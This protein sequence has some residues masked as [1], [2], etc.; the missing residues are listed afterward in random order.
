MA[1]NLKSHDAAAIGWQ[2]WVPT[3]AEPWNV[4]RVAHLHRRAGFAANWP[5]I[6][7]DLNDGHHRSIQRLLDGGAQETAVPDDF[8]SLA[9][10]IGNAAGSSDSPRRLQAWWVYRMIYSP[11]PLGERLSL[12]WHQHFATS[13][14]KVNNVQAVYQQ[15]Q[16]FR[17]YGRGDFGELFT[18]VLR[19]PAMLVYLDADSNRAS[20]PNENLGREM[21]ELFSVGEGNFTQADVT[22]AARA[23]T[24]WT[25][26]SNEF[27]FDTAHHDDGEKE[28]L[29][30]RG[31]WTG[32]DALA[33]ALDHPATARRITWRICQMLMGENVVSNQALDVLTN[34]F[35]D[36]Q[37][38]IGWLVETILRSNLFFDKANIG[39]RVR[40]ATEF[41]IGIIRATG[42]MTPPPSTL[43]VADWTRRLGQQLF[44]PPNVF[45]FAEGRQWINSQW[46]ISRLRFVR[47]LLRGKLH[48]R[49]FDVTET[50]RQHGGRIGRRR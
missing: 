12:L 16:L 44:Y 14:A 20:H 25:V 15:N 24:G 30:R 4:G 31:K 18:R 42:A 23:L 40:G 13:N 7:R 39:N 27:Y 17:K 21:L 28:L 33:I 43:A 48:Q 32:D 26:K 50:F 35:R 46:L 47:Q 9:E 45:G 11:D 22:D 36:K 10:V 29:G 37:M 3:K 49:K 2:P 41:M 34:Q 8:D 5:E 38:N 6:Q 19:G 1:V